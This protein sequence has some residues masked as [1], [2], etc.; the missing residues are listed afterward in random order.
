[1]MGI[2]ALA[3][4][5]IA[6]VRCISY[7]AAAARDGNPCGAIAAILLAAASVLCTILQAY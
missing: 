1:M 2:A 7:G 5:I 4:S 6:A 3:I